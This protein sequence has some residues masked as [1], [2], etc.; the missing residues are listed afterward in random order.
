MRGIAKKFK[1]GKRVDQVTGDPNAGALITVYSECDEAPERYNF[2]GFLSCRSRFLQ[3]H[4]R[5]INFDPLLSPSV[6]SGG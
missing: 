4:G 5:S 2:A 1:R 6:A 3:V